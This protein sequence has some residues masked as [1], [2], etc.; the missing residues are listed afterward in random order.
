MY[1]IPDGAESGSVPLAFVN[2]PY[3]K[4]FFEYVGVE[5]PNRD[6]FRLAY[7]PMILKNVEES[8]QKRIQLAKYINV[9]LDGWT[10]VSGI[11]YVAVLLVFD[12]TCEYIGNLEMED[13]RQDASAIAEALYSLLQKH[14]MYLTKIVAVVSDSAQSCGWPKIS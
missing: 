6:Q 3:L 4:D 10:D 12:G 11:Y 13:R 8:K 7:L 14:V 2:D 9:I 5:M 1:Q